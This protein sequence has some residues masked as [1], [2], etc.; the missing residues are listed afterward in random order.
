M[1]G[2]S[3]C[4]IV[5]GNSSAWLLPQSEAIK[6]QNDFHGNSSVLDAITV[7]LFL[8]NGRRNAGEGLRSS[9]SCMVS[10]IGPEELEAKLNKDSS[11]NSELGLFT[12]LFRP[13]IYAI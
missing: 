7:S 9:I 12:V 4:T 3:R 8:I 11:V 2:N 5:I 13:I 6:E 10:T 1:S